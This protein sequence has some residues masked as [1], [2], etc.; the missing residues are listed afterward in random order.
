MILHPNALHEQDE[1]ERH[2]A[3]IEITNIQRKQNLW[4]ERQ[5]IHLEKFHMSQ[6]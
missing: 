2:L 5:T 3:K 6:P 4:M 1:D